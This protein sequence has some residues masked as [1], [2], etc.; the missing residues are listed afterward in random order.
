ML[1][2]AFAASALLIAGTTM[3]SADS[4]ERRQER[5]YDAS[6]PAVRTAPSPGWRA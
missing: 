3:A 1:K 4:V 2:T 5:Q 6:K